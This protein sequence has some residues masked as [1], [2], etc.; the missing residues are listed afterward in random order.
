MSGSHNVTHFGSLRSYPDITTQENLLNL[1]CT[2]YIFDSGDC[3]L[4]Y[5]VSGLLRLG[6]QILD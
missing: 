5:S 3:V 6:L 4:I 2:T 1:K